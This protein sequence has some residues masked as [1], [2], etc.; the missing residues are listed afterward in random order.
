M[1]LKNRIFKLA[2]VALVGCAP[3][4]ALADGHSASYDIRSIDDLQFGP[5]GEG[6]VEIAVLW[7]DPSSGP[8]GFILK[9]P[10]GFEAPVHSHT[11]SYRAVVIE[12]AALHWLG[13]EDKDSAAPLSAGGYWLQPGG[14]LHGDANASDGTSLA[15]VIFD[16]TLDF[17]L[18]E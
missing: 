15:L 6:P 11:A 13:T 2:A 12:G 5:F 14:Q 8:S 3:L 7:G 9:I 16:G 10:A 18:P 4:T 1:P 17:M